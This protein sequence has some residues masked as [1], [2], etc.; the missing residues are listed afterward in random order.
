MTDCHSS[1]VAR[2]KSF[3]IRVE[4]TVDDERPQRGRDRPPTIFNLSERSREPVIQENHER[5]VTPAHLKNVLNDFQT[6]MTVVVQEQI[7][8]NMLFFQVNPD[9]AV[10]NPPK[11]YSLEG[12]LGPSRPPRQEMSKRPSKEKQPAISEHRR[13]MDRKLVVRTQDNM[14]PSGH[15]MERDAREYLEAKKATALQRSALGSNP[16][17]RDP[18]LRLPSKTEG[19]SLGLSAIQPRAAKACRSAN[20]K[21][22]G[23]Q[24]AY[25]VR[26]ESKFKNLKK[27]KTTAGVSV[28]FLGENVATGV[29]LEDQIALGK[30]LVL[31]GSTGTVRSQKDAA[32]GANLEVRLREAD[33]PIGQDQS[34]FVLSLM[35]WRGDLAIVGNLQSQISVGRGSN[36]VVRVALN[37]KQSGQITARTSSSDH[38]A[39]AYAGLMPIALA[40][41]QKLRPNVSENYS[42]Y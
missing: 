32:Y 25:I 3:G 2:N 17:L 8:N 5:L 22:I 21:T 36:M 7:K 18:P 19:R 1:N 27:N 41:Y 29:K 23:K 40:L 20:S 12:P 33:Y 28:T 37:N 6:K 42:I 16:Y 13:K 34:S 39:L 15:R 4:D 9:P 14:H 30:R 11:G 24:L 26:G 31:V 35:K 10:V 38:L